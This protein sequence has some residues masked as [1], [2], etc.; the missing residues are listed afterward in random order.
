MLMNDPAPSFRP[1]SQSKG[2]TLVELLVAVVVLAIG[3]LGMAGLQTT[4]LN[5]NQSAYY[6]T[7]ATN[8]ISDILDR[9]RANPV[10]LEA[11]AYDNIDVASNPPSAQTCITQDSGCTPL[12][13]AN[14][15][16]REWAKLFVDV[17][18][19]G[20][21]FRPQLPGATGTVSR[22]N[23]TSVFTVTVTWQET[24]WSANRQKAIENKTLSMRVSL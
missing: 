3:L 20:S 16:I 4:G 9:M 19:E 5:T 22:T 24:D 12:Q 17:D 6:R 10:G 11:G 14:Y 8:A 2:F 23:G 13:L 7:Q 21:D 18:N 15:D 1:A